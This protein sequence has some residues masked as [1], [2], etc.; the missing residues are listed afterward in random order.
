MKKYYSLYATPIRR[1]AFIVALHNAWFWV[2]IWVL[3]YRR[4]TGYGGVALLESLSMGIYLLMIIPGGMLSDVL[5]RKRLLILASLLACIGAIGAGLASSFPFL[6]LSIL[7]LSSSS[8]LYQASIEALIYD[9]LKSE[10]QEKRYEIVL[11]KMTTVRMVSCAISSA[12]GGW[13]Y[14]LDPRFPWFAVSVMT[15][16][17]ALVA[18]TIIEPRIEKLHDSFSIFLKEAGKGLLLLFRQQWRIAIPILLF[19]IFLTMDSSGLWDIQAVSYGYSSTQLGF[20]LTATYIVLAFCSLILPKLLR[21]IHER[22]VIF[23]SIIFFAFLW[24]VSGNALGVLGAVLLIGRSI[25]SVMF[26]I[27]SSVIWNRMIP[28]SIRATTLSTVVIIRGIPYIIIAFSLGT[29]LDSIGI[30]PVICTL[31]GALLSLFFGMQFIW[32]SDKNK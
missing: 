9:S 10:G 13:M 19:G 21:K 3:Y 5:G 26:D 4:F 16:I 32:K 1:I 12:I 7:V 28:S 17:S 27:K 2:P 20:F 8:G 11:G 24:F 6:I 31:S 23:I 15:L 29:L 30:R 25:M 22:T 18:C 14:W